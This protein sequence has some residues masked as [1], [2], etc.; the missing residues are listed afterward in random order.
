VCRS[1]CERHAAPR[2]GVAGVAIYRSDGTTWRRCWPR[3]IACT[4]PRRP[5]DTASRVRRARQRPR[6]ARLNSARA[7]HRI[8]LGQLVLH[9]QPRVRVVTPPSAWKRWCAGN[10]AARAA[11]PAHFIDIPRDRLDRGPC[12]LGAAPR[13]PDL[14]RLQH[15]GARA[16]NVSQREA[17][18]CKN[19]RL[20][21]SR[22]DDRVRRLRSAPDRTRAHEA[23]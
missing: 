3:R 10:T 11:A 21:T 17:R 8:D 13:G 22:R 5:G 2:H 14:A 19:P 1:S 9:Y 12:R 4:A 20:S 18:Q 6:R 15:G 16:G 7:A 23:R